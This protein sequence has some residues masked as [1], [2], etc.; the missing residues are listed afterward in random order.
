MSI[1]SVRCRTCGQSLGLSH[2]VENVI[3]EG[4]EQVADIR[5]HVKKLMKATDKQ[6]ANALGR[7]TRHG[8]ISRVGYGKYAR[9][10]GK[11]K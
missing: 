10:R 9:G 7:L 8:R 1:L 5:L 11:R 6:I 3:A 4:H 2:I